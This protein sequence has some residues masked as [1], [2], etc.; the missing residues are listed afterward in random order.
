M[1]G[2][3]PD[4]PPEV[5]ELERAA[6]WRLRKVDADPSDQRSAAAARHLQK[7]AD[8]LRLLRGSALYREYMAICNWL[9]ES[10]GL[11][12]FEMVA[13]DFRANIGF[14][15]WAETGEAYLRALIDM[16]RETS[17]TG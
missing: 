11:S 8:E 2:A 14:G 16:A 17:G 3:Q 4:D 6:E 15:T 12:E 10:D 9:G 5:T 7:L 1:T 13:H